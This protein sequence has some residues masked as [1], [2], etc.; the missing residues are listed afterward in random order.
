MKRRDWRPLLLVTLL[1]TPAVLRPAAAEDAP[2][3]LLGQCTAAQ[4]A[5]EPYAEWFAPGYSGYTPNPAVVEALR[6]VDFE[7]VA[8][9]VFFGTWCRDSRREVPRM[10]QLLDTLGFPEADRRLIAVDNSDELHKRSPDG[11]EAGLGIFRVPTFLVKRDGEEVARIVEHPALSL[12]R[13]LLTILEGRDYQPSYATYP[14]IRRWL[15]EGLLADPNVNADGLANQIRTLVSSEWELRSAVRVLL[16]RGDV[17]EAAKLSEVNCSLYWESATCHAHLAEAQ[18]R[19]GDR[20]GARESIQRAL[21]RNDD[22]DR[23]EELMELLERAT[24][25]DAPSP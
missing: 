5:A 23:V 17:A 13:D 11:E 14:V 20:E 16:S 21:E 4:L 25:P 7:G 10:L 8:I 12:E 19:A 6:R 9:D 3:K 18:L 15:R 2:P 22:P 24:A 1:A